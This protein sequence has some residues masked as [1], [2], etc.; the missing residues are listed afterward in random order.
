MYKRIIIGI[1]FLI[2]LG[3]S[4]GCSSKNN[5]KSGSAETI[6]SLRF[7]EEYE[8]I[9]DE[10]DDDGNA[11]YTFLSVNKENNI[12]Y[13]TYEELLD[14]I[15]SKT[16]LLYFGRPACPWCR[17]LVPHMLEFAQADNINIYYY[18]IE[19]DRAENNEN[20]KKILSILGDYLPTDTVTQNEDDLNFD[21]D[22]KRVVLP[23]LFFIKKG[24]IKADLL[25]FQHEYL[26]DDKPEEVIQLL[27]DSYSSTAS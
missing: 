26:R 8:A 20:Y 7:K 27:R 18:D 17:L 16:G 14:F 24:E 13:L 3:I 19:N 15:E 23:Q 12:V 6:D 11:K 1:S 10:L 22:L 9:N 21:P 25:F 4:M 5:N 2:M